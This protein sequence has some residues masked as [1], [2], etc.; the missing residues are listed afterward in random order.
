MATDQLTCRELVDLVT[1]YVENAL[2]PAERVRF[3][4]HRDL[5]D[6]CRNHLDQMQTTIR[7]AGRLRCSDLSTEAEASLLAAFHTWKSQ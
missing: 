2:S 3:E 6:G 1:D 7:L 4:R 5:C